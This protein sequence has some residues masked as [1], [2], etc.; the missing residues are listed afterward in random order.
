MD[1]IRRLALELTSLLEQA[2]QRAQQVE[3]ASVKETSE[4]L[5]LLA[6]VRPLRVFAAQEPPAPSKL[7]E[8]IEDMIDPEFGLR[9]ARTVISQAAERILNGYDAFHMPRRRGSSDGS[10]GSSSG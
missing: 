7:D 8:Y 4:L 9:P 2:I 1:E 6:A 5:T 3:D 10:D